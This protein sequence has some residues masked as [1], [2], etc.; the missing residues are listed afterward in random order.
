MLSTSRQTTSQPDPYIDIHTSINFVSLYLLR[1]YSYDQFST[2]HSSVIP[3][4]SLF[5]TLYSVG[6]LLS[7]AFSPLPYYSRLQISI[8]IELGVHTSCHAISSRNGILAQICH[9][10]DLIA[11]L[12]FCQE[13]KESS[14]YLFKF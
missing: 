14:Q 5:P 1:Y 11:T 13:T 6:P 12:Y 3:I 7:R 8:L 2:I 4:L 9:K 10:T